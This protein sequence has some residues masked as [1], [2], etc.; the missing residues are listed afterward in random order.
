MK[1][2]SICEKYVQTKTNQTVEEYVA[3]NNT[4]KSTVCGS[5]IKMAELLAAML[6]VN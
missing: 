2:S 1:T 6:T 5:G 3:Q 4:M